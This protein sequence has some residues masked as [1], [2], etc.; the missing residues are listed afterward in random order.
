MLL[1]AFVWSMQTADSLT[2]YD[3]AVRN[4]LASLDYRATS[5]TTKAETLIAAIDALLLLRPQRAQFGG[6]AGEQLQFESAS[7]LAVR[8]ATEKWL[9]S[10]RVATIEPQVGYVDTTQYIE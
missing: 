3:D 2:A 5:S 7:L 6:T 1:R 9:R 10:Y 4:Y 8:T